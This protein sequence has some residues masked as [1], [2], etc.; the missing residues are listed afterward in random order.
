M[1]ASVLEQNPN[2]KMMPLSRAKGEK[3][4][5]KGFALTDKTDDR[6]K[7]TPPAGAQQALPPASSSGSA[8][9]AKKKPAAAAKEAAASTKKKRGDKDFERVDLVFQ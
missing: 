3:Y 9:V 1:A 2:S 4:A 5:N 8:P 7:A 6:G